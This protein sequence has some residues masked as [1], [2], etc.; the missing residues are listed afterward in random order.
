[1]CRMNIT[2]CVLLTVTFQFAHDIFISNYQLS[3]GIT[4]KATPAC[5]RGHGLLMC[6]GSCGMYQSIWYNVAED[7]NFLQYCCDNL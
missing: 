1:M 4:C 6:W 7:S 5:L 3:E 2:R